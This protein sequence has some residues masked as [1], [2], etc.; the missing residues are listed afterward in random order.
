[1]YKDWR[2]VGFNKALSL[3]LNFPSNL[4]Q[5]LCTQINETCRL[6]ADY[7]RLPVCFGIDETVRTD[8]SEA[9]KILFSPWFPGFEREK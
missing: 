2:R 7:F 3:N 4:S 1:L 6:I 9:I 8:C 5:Y